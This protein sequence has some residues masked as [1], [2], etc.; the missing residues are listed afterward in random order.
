MAFCLP[1]VRHINT[2]YSLAVGLL[3][4]SSLVVRAQQYSIPWYT[5]AGGGGS[6]AG[7]VYSVT[8]TIGQYA[9]GHLSGGNYSIDG[10]FWGLIAAVQTPGAP[11][12]SIKTL[13]S[14]V[15]ISWTNTG[16]I[17]NLQE[18]PNLNLASGWTAVSQTLVLTNGLNTVTVTNTGG[19]LFFRLKQ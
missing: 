13:N 8:G 6:S 5:I 3:L 9:A 19:N 17:F 15:I 4:G 11:V 16:S 14:Q 2:F 7:G 18:S 12:L 10:G 1:A